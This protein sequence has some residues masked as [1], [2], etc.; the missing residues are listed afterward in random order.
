MS[1]APGDEQLRVH[2]EPIRGGQGVFARLPLA[3]GAHILDLRGVVVETPNRRTL[4]LGRN[5]HLDLPAGTSDAE[6]RLLFPWRFL[7][8]GCAPNGGIDERA[9]VAL[10]PIA[11]GEEIQFDYNTTEW[12]LADAFACGCAAPGC[13]GAPVRGFRYLSRAERGQRRPLLSAHLR[14]RLGA[15]AR[16]S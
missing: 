12:E 7:N 15:A 13:A 14:D 10:R 4:Q 5:E 8:H 9:L 1:N 3:A 2:V 16:D 6:A 11:A